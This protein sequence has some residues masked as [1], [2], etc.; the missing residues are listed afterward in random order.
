MP[1]REDRLRLRH[2]LDASREA[3]ELIAGL[4]KAEVISNRV[5]TLALVRLLEVVGE[6]AARIRPETQVQSTAIPGRRLSACG[7]A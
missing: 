5:L 1:L 4:N 6:A 3:V 7:I 2:I